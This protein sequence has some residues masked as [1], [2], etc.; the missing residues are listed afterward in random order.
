MGTRQIVSRWR[1]WRIR[2]RKETS[3]PLDKC[4]LEEI[5]VTGLACAA[6][7]FVQAALNDT[8]PSEFAISVLA[9]IEA[10]TAIENA[11]FEARN[12]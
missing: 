12:K 8:E 2:L 5:G 9:K 11:M 1:F 4:G 7:S 10:D 3:C 6:C